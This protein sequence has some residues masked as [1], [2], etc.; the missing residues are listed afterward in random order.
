MKTTGW[1]A[2]TTTR[3]AGSQP[4][5][6]TCAN[7]RDEIQF[8]RAVQVYLWALPAMNSVA[9]RDAQAASTPHARVAG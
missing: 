5:K 6:G 1:D 9:M 7:P 2:P 3:F 8:Q 4:S